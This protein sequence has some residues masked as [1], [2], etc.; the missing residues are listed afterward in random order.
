[1]NSYWYV[2]IEGKKYGPIDINTLRSWIREGRVGDEDMVWHQSFGSD[3]RKVSQVPQLGMPPPPSYTQ[4]S[5]PQ[6][7][8]YP[9]SK[10]PQYMGVG[11]GV[12]RQ[13][14]EEAKRQRAKTDKIMSPLWILAQ[15]LGIIV[16]LLFPFIAGLAIFGIESNE[17]VL[18]DKE[19]DTRGIGMLVFIIIGLI[20]GA[21]IMIYPWY[22]LIK[23]RSEHFRRDILL[24]E[25]IIDLLREKSTTTSA[26]L[27][28]EIATLSSLHAEA[29][30]VEEYKNPIVHIIIMIII[31][32]IGAMYVLYFLMKDIF[33]HHNKVIAFM[34]N[35]QNAL[36]KLGFAI[37]APTWKVLPS[38]SF[39]VYFILAC[40]I[41]L[42]ALYWQYTIIKDYND[43]F[44]AQWQ[45]EDQLPNVY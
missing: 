16:M 41:P 1:M 15:I 7:P 37:V 42:F 3:W 40:C 12:G 31:P 13:K 32:W 6:P 23:R 4:P 11:R 25:G 34:Q 33:A 24:R 2:E 38:R 39:A 22:L 30:S 5:Y 8:Q 29:C 43:H 21:L 44:K 45:F 18:T 14:I 19:K 10:P 20:V 36:N 27:N 35:T 17:K 26:N 9:P 28:Q